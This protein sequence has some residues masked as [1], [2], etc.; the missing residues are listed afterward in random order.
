MEARFHNIAAY[1]NIIYLLNAPTTNSWPHAKEKTQSPIKLTIDCL[2]D[3][4]VSTKC[5]SICA[6]DLMFFTRGNI[7]KLVDS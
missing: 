4:H 3:K 6:Y 5:Y 1:N 7:T 2:S